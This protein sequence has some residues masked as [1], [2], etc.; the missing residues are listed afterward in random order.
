MNWPEKKKSFLNEVKAEQ[1][2]AEQI[3]FFCKS[4]KK[5]GIVC[6]VEIN[7][8]LKTEKLLIRWIEFD[9]YLVSK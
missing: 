4:A 2:S 3:Y 1:F 9:L 6:S 8:I 7:L 5:I